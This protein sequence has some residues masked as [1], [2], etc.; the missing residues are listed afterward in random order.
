MKVFVLGAGVI[1]VA[2]AHCSA[3]D[4]HEGTVV[5]R[6]PAPALETSF[7]N[8]ATCARA[9]RRRGPRRVCVGKR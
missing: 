9:T 5:E 6:Q 1:G 4:G 2:T 3:E 8:P 7:G